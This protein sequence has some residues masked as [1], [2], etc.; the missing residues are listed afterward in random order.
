MVVA[1]ASRTTRTLVWFGIIRTGSKAKRLFFAR[2]IACRRS[3]TC[4][5]LGWRCANISCHY[6]SIQ[7]STTRVSYVGRGKN[8]AKGDCHWEKESVWQGRAA[9]PPAHKE[10][11]C[12]ACDELRNICKS[13]KS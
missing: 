10:S 7:V 4:S 11:P 12:E 9:V 3:P 6:S 5:Y 8:S 13:F 1:S 2:A